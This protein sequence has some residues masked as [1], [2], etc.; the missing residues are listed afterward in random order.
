MPNTIPDKKRNQA[1]NAHYG[2]NNCA[3]SLGNTTENPPA[4]KGPTIQHIR[5]VVFFKAVFSARGMG[6]RARR[7]PKATK[8]PELLVART[9][10]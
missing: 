8:T 2:D 7:M 4:I 3:I 9:I 10:G 5:S 6:F 1:D